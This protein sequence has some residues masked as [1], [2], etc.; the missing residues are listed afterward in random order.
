VKVGDLVRYK[1]MH[2]LPLVSV[3]I[4]LRTPEETHNGDSEV[5]FKHRIRFCRGKLMEV[6]SESR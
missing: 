1:T 2:A 6:V 3:G 4:V 5:L